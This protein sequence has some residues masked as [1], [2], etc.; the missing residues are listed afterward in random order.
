M[1]DKINNLS[2]YFGGGIVI[3]DL[4]LFHFIVLLNPH[5][6]CSKCFISFSLDRVT[7]GRHNFVS[8]I[9]NSNPVVATIAGGSLLF[10]ASNIS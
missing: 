2:C 7:T 6:N 9:L 10:P 3:C 4:F 5:F 1:L 8:V